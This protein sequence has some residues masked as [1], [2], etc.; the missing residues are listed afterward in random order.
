MFTVL[1]SRLRFVFLLFATLLGL[2]AAPAAQANVVDAL[3]TC[4]NFLKAQ[5]YARAETEAKDLLQ[6]NDLSR[7]EQRYAQLCLGRAYED[8]GRAQDALTAFQQVE[9]LSQTTKELAI[10][11]NYLGIIY[12]ELNDLDRAELNDQRAIKAFKELGESGSE[13]AALNNLAMVVEKRGDLERALALY[14]ESLELAPDKAKKHATLNNIGLIYADRK[15]YGKGVAILRQAV[16]I[17]SR[18]GDAHS[19]AK[20]QLNLGVVLRRQ[21]KLKDSEKEL[22]AGL[23]AIRLVGDKHWEA[24]ACKSLAN[25]AIARKKTPLARDWY[26]KAEVLYREIGDTESAD[27]MRAESN[28]LKK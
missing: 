28:Q 15:E 20:W 27:K 3:N 9:S 8:M 6:R 14:Q 1:S 24:N 17:A 5:D 4:F 13:S 22:T 16:E 10:A 7:T 2:V 26:E 12:K 21:G 19:A 25:L 18:S 23:N 11:Y